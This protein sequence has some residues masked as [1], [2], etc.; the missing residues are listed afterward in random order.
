MSAARAE[1]LILGLGNLVCGDDGLGVV[2]LE[3][4]RSGYLLPPGVELLD[5][6]TLG[7][8][9]LPHLLDS[10][11]AI[12]IDAIAAEGPPATLVTLA[13]EEVAHAAHHRL[14]VHQ[15]GVGDLLDAGRLMGELPELALV[16]MVPGPVE[17]S[18]E[19]S[20]PVAEAIPALVAAVVAQAARWGFA[21]GP[22]A[23]PDPVL[24]LPGSVAQPRR[25]A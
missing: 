11:R 21:L 16:G 7:L 3:Q 14:S 12:L 23:A 18:V 15:V 13:G 2:A 19:L 4:L 5:G 6:G 17:L 8:S 24:G 22:K 10:R 25:G 20:E 1:L 9:L